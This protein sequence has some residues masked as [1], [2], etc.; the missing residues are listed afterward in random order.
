MTEKL[1]PLSYYKWHWQSWRANRKVQR[2]TYIERGL[3]RELLDECWSEGF[4]PNNIELMAEICGCPVETMASAWQVLS[5][6][7]VLLDGVFINERMDRERTEKDFERAKRARA[8]KVGGLHKALNSNDNLASAKQVPSTCH[9]EE[10]RRE[11]K[12]LEKN[13]KEDHP[14]TGVVRWSAST[15]ELPFSINP[16]AWQS[17]CKYKSEAKKP[18][19]QTSAKLQWDFLSSYQPDTQLEIV[20]QSI[21][22]GWHGLFAPKS[23]NTKQSINDKISDQSRFIPL[24]ADGSF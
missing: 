16:A 18:I 24:D 6:C 23:G 15:C 19:K 10:K 14:P 13:R 9:I 1:P 22:N 11:E 8:G 3:Y 20:N 7:F 5:N 12:S 17:W 2:M 4:V 21:R